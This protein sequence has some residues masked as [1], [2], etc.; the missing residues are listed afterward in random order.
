MKQPDAQSAIPT[1]ERRLYRLLAGVAVAVWLLPWLL[2][3]GKEAWDHWTYFS[4]SVPVMAML[5]AYAG[6]RV[7]ARA[8]RWPLT[9]IL[10]QF[11][12]A[13][14]LGGFGNLLPLGIIAFTILGVPMIIAAFVGAWLGRRKEQRVS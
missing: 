1:L 13:L 4:I 7:P 2:L 5:A 14:F 9:L 10:A 8:W 3:N 6:Y 12:A 11:A